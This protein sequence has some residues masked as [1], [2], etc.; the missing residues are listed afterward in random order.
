MDTHFDH[1]FLNIIG[2]L[3][4]F[5]ATVIF[6]RASIDF[7]TRWSK[8]IPMSNI[9]ADTVTISFSWSMVFHFRDAIQDHNWKWYPVWIG[10]I[11]C[12]HTFTIRVLVAW[13]TDQSPP[14]G[15]SQRHSW[16]LK[17]DRSFLCSPSTCTTTKS[18]YRLLACRPLRPQVRALRHLQI[19]QYWTWDTISM[20]FAWQCNAY[21]HRQFAFNI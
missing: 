13:Q 16:S 5:I 3:Q 15:V 11:P 19:F 18:F 7:F 21:T 6:S 1:V 20:V 9:T 2:P 17:S 8:A 14:Q 12:G 4:H 10:T